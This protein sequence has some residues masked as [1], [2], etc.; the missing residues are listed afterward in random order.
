MNTAIGGISPSDRPM[1]SAAV[2]SAYRFQQ[3]DLTPTDSVQ[4]SREVLSLRGVDGDVRLDK[5][6]S[7]KKD[8]AEGRLYTAEAWGRAINRALDDI[9]SP[10]K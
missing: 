10:A 1:S 2:K 8:L 7:V 5:V 4:L 9:F 3:P 6:M